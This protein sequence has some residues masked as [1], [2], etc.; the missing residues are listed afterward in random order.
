MGSGFSND[1]CVCKNFNTRDDGTKSAQITT[2][3]QLLIGATAAPNVRVGT[4]TSIG[5]SVTITPG[6]GTIDLAANIGAVDINALA[7]YPLTVPHGGTART[8]FPQGSILIGEVTNPL[9]S[10][11]LGAG[12]LL[13][14]SGAGVDPVAYTLPAGNNITWTA[15]I[16]TLHAD[17]TGVTPNAMVYGSAAGSLTSLA[18]A[19]NG[20][21][22]IG[23]TGNPPVLATISAGAGISITNAPGSI[24]IAHTGAAP[25]YAYTEPGAY[26]YDVLS[27]D[28]LVGVDTAAA[29][30]IRMPNAPTTGSM[31]VIKDVVGNAAAQNISVTTV[32]GAVLIDVAATYTMNVNYASI[33]LF[34]NGVKYLVI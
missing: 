13:V 17:L 7:G 31:W 21:V 23:S 20:Q 1:T 32:G 19:T 2:D 6:A 14:G 16:G 4:L 33:T 24:T 12:Q 11:V 22:P 15:G 25:I 30:T 9:N 5:G 10:V 27:T 28:Y 29:R 8:T 3:G 26:P 18:V 34:F